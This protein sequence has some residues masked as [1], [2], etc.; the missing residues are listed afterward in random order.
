M[1]DKSARYRKLS[2]MAVEDQTDEQIQEQVDLYYELYVQE[3]EM[4]ALDARLER[5]SHFWPEI[6]VEAA[7]LCE[8]CH[9]PERHCICGG[10]F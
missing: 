8:G 10:E 4:Q 1:Q 7:E 6:Q 5:Q 2:A 9:R 3:Q